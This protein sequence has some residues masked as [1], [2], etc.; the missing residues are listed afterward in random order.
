[1]EQM[2]RQ[3]ETRNCPDRLDCTEANDAAKQHPCGKN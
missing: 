3:T 1:M 2:T